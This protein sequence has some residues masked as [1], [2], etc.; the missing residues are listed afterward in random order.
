MNCAEF[1]K[2]V[3]MLKE[4][5]YGN[6]TR[7]AIIEGLVAIDTRYKDTDMKELL[8]RSYLESVYRQAWVVRHGEAERLNYNDFEYE[9]IVGGLNKTLF[10]D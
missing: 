6:R 3:K 7:R 10:R 9:E 8:E 1:K 2:N 4:N 5:G